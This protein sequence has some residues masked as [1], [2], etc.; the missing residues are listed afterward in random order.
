MTTITLSRSERAQLLRVFDCDRS[1]TR[2]C[3]LFPRIHQML[4][5]MEQWGLV[6]RHEYAPGAESWTITDTGREALDAQL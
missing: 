5:R 3:N 2:L 6:S 1:V 4:L